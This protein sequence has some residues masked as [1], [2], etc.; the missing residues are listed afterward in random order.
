[1][2]RVTL[3]VTSGPHAGKR[4]TLSRG[5]SATFGR[6]PEADYQFPDDLLMSSRHFAVEVDGQ[7]CRVRDL[8]S[9]NGTYVDDKRI[10]ERTL[11]GGS[12]I[13]AGDTKFS[14]TL[15]EAAP[16]TP[17]PPLP[18]LP[19]SHAPAPASAA[20]KSTAPSGLQSPASADFFAAGH[21][22][23]PPLGSSTPPLSSPP[24]RQDL[25]SAAPLTATKVAPP[26]DRWRA[27]ASREFEL[28]LDDPDPGVR[29]NALFAAA[30]QGQRWVL[31]YCRAVAVRPV[32]E[33]WDALWLLCVL[34]QAD[35]LPRIFVMA[36]AAELGPP[37]LTLL[38]VYGHPQVMSDLLAALESKD[39]E[40]SRAAAGAFEKITGSE[41]RAR[42]ES[43]DA[44]PDSALAGR[45]WQLLKA[46]FPTAVRL[47]RGHDISRG[48]PPENLATLDLESRW[49][50][51][52]RGRFA[53]R[54][55]RQPLDA[56]QLADALHGQSPTSA[57]T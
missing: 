47:C 39:A 53:N 51:C 57:A 26:R 24:T 42:A 11:A 10:V 5:Q 22:A 41:V 6:T 9:R 25:P 19:P 33:N 46:K 17:L 12:V 29:R 23:F 14:V 1:M 49:E 48:L 3:Q 20:A 13:L 37:R 16:L 15:T 28:A 7:G 45:A 38:G 44:P 4:I 31:D 36:R 27:Q 35:D 50:A 56:E 43:A 54:W 55:E 52:L 34:G 2:M 18:P 21:V 40:L 30:W 32:P 8:E